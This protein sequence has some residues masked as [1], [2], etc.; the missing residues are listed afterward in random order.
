MILHSHRGS[1]WLISAQINH[2]KCNVLISTFRKIIAILIHRIVSFFTALKISQHQCTL[3]VQRVFRVSCTVVMFER[4]EANTDMHC[5][6][7]GEIM[8]GMW[9]R[10]NAMEKNVD[11]WFW[12]Y[13]WKKYFPIPTST[14]FQKYSSGWFDNYFI[15]FNGVLLYIYTLGLGIC[16]FYCCPNGLYGLF[17]WL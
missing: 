5:K 12:F 8:G 9:M 13:L 1:K 7:M 2:G 10:K 3:F 6:I 11:S 16:F 15:N 14:S 4:G 17:L